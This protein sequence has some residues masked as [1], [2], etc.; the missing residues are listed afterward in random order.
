M[1]AANEKIGLVILA[2]GDVLDVLLGTARL[3]AGATEIGVEL[4]KKFREFPVL[5]ST[6][7]VAEL[8]RVVKGVGQAALYATGVHA[9]LSASCT[10][11]RVSG[12][13][14]A[15]KPASPSGRTRG[16]HSPRPTF[17]ARWPSRS[18][19]TVP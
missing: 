9:A 1:D 11:N 6:E 17:A 14:C 16:W 4:N 15:R 18:T 8:E 19:P 2:A 12:R 10:R 7:A 5:I 3:V 13:R